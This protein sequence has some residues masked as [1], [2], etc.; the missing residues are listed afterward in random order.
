MCPAL[1]SDGT[2]KRHQEVPAGT[3]D[4]SDVSHLQLHLDAIDGQ[5]FILEREGKHGS[6]G[7]L[8]PALAASPVVHRTLRLHEEEQSLEFKD[9]KTCQIKLVSTGSSLL[10]E[11]FG[12]K[13]FLRREL[14]AWRR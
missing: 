10:D 1:Q 4:G 13:A 8:F 6:E 7:T 11:T 14:L 9:E 5:D 2:I 3:F 12:L